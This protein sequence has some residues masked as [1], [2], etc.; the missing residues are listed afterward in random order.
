MVN[1]YPTDQQ[2]LD[3]KQTR[4]GID[5]LFKSICSYL[6][7]YV[8]YTYKKIIQDWKC[9]IWKTKMYLNYIKEAPLVY[10]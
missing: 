1:V 2:T 10:N 3:V 4:Q 8:S 5:M 9:L 6:S 7:S